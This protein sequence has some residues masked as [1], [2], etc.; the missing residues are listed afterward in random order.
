MNETLR[1]LKNFV[2][3][4]QT[5]GKSFMKQY[6]IEDYHDSNMKMKLSKKKELDKP[7]CF[8]YQLC[9]VKGVSQKIAKVIVSKHP[10]WISLYKAIETQETEKGIR[11]NK[12]MSKIRYCNKTL[13]SQAFNKYFKFTRMHFIL[14]IYVC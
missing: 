14:F 2:W 4:M 13:K 8:L 7:T 9:Q 1:F 3:K 11:E 6:T 5:Q 10:S 12:K